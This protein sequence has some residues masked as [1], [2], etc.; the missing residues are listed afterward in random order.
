MFDI[1]NHDKTGY[2]LIAAKFV[3]GYIELTRNLIQQLSKVGDK[4]FVR[5][6]LLDDNTTESKSR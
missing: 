2:D 3:T 1:I 4:E 5:K 6:I